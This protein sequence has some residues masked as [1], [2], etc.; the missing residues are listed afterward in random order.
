MTTA[1]PRI[2]VPLDGSA[3]AEAA[4]PAAA[5]IAA[6]R[7][8]AV[9]LLHVVETQPPETV[10]GHRHLGTKSE[11]L[12]YL[13]QRAD[14]LRRR[15]FEVE[16]HAHEPRAR[17][18]AEALAMHAEEMETDL[19]VLCAHGSGGLRDLFLGNIAQQ[20]LK[21]CIRPVLL[22]RPPAPPQGWRLGTRPWIVA[23]DPSGHGW[24]SLPFVAGLAHALG[25]SLRLLTVIPT[26]DTLPGS[27]RAGATLAPR[28]VSVVLDLEERDAAHYLGDVARTLLREGIEAS[29]EVVR[30][31]RIDEALRVLEREDGALLVVATHTK[32]GIGGLLSGSFAMSAAGRTA[33]PVLLV[34]IQPQSLMQR[35]RPS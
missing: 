19:I 3:L 16:V 30:G 33:R 32:A 27:R 20:T 10:H 7:G 9:T 24:G 34:P 13:E 14:E 1:I 25:T 26:R 28:T 31:G 6:A 5:E 17:D 21:R 2:L 15:G 8:A 22:V 12:V 23:V 29:V 11:A 4:L 18:V 35:H